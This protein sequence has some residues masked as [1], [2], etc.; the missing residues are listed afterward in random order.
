MRKFI[1][2]S[3]VLFSGVLLSQM[4]AA[5]EPK[6]ETFGDWGYQCEKAPNG[7]GDFCYVFQNVTKKDTQ[8]LV[9]GARV[10]YR[11][12]QKDPLLV[13]TV[14]LGTLLP[15]GAALV[16]DGVEGVEPLKLPFFLCAAEGCTTVATGMPSALI[17]AMKKAEMASIRIAAPNKQVVGLP[18]SLKGFTKAIAKIKK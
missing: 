3:L 4:A 2:A 1:A 5:E 13:V 9:L 6:I 14:P 7:E 17:E 16:L 18:L 10:A 15:P 8:Q 12:E 11:P